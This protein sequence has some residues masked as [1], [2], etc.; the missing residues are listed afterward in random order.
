MDPRRLVAMLLLCSLAWLVRGC[1]IAPWEPHEKSAQGGSPPAA[2]T[3]KARQHSQPEATAQSKNVRAREL[4]KS[5]ESKP[6]LTQPPP[7]KVGSGARQQSSPAEKPW[8]DPDAEGRKGQEGVQ[9]L[10]LEPMA[11]AAEPPP[12][13]EPQLLSAP[14]PA[15]EQEPAPE[16]ARAARAPE[17][18]VERAPSELSG[19]TGTTASPLDP[20]SGEPAPR[21][22]LVPPALGTPLVLPDIFSPEPISERPVALSLPDTPPDGWFEE[23]FEHGQPR[24][25]RVPRLLREP[26]PPLRPEGEP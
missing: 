6:L 24:K 14:E 12:A 11:A 15:Q 10:T 9:E 4:P 23:A 16:P 20:N 18:T 13:P 2:I 7:P 25:T 5:I 1:A 19:P 3:Q 22:V 17:P 26:S 8:I 21:G